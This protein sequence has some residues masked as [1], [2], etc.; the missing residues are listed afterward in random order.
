MKH[1]RLFEYIDAVVRAGSIRRA[2]ETL[3]IT[4]SAL[5]R[6]IQQV[7]EELGTQIFERHAKGMRLTAAGEIFL[8][9]VRRHMAD[10]D[11]V[12]S[13]IEGLKGLRKGHV[14]I[15][16]SQALALKFLPEQIR[17]FRSRYPGVSFSVRIADRGE[18]LKSLIAFEADLAVVVFPKM[19]SEVMQLIMVAQP[20]VALMSALHPLAAQPTVRLSEC[21]NY[22]LVLPDA[23]LGVRELLQPILIRRTNKA[24]ISAET[25]SFELMRGLLQDQRSIG[26]QI[27]IGTPDSLQESTIISRPIDE[28]DVP[29]APLICAQLR[30]RTL[31]VAAARFADQL[32]QQ[33]DNMNLSV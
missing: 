6:R 14:A 22:P 26:F 13:E 30:G 24:Q 1:L 25:N 4:P 11:R 18:A 3:Y 23:S 27:A 2:S 15:V 10:L 33:L 31:S 7:E 5:D 8:D 9:Y 29:A 32:T 21:L 20:V 28:R 16:A 12:R 17:L 19:S